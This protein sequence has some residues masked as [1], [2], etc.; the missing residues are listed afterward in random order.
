MYLFFQLDDAITEK[1]KTFKDLRSSFEKEKE[2]ADEE[3]QK[4]EELE[5]TLNNMKKEMAAIMKKRTISGESDLQPLVS[6]I[7]FL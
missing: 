6:T 4:R 7:S 5:E 2:R 1:E 3:K